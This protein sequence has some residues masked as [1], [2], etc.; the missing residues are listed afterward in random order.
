MPRE[1]MKTISR[2]RTIKILKDLKRPGVPL[3]LIFSFFLFLALSS[4]SS[5]SPEKGVFYTAG[6]WD[7]PPAYHGNP[8]APGGV[9]VAGAYV[10]EPLFVYNPRTGKYID[11]LGKSFEVSP[12]YKTLTV[13]LKDNVFWHDGYEFSS[14]DVKTTIY[15]G[16]LRNMEIWRNLE[17]VEC[18]DENTVIF[19][20]KKISPTNNIRAL[21][22][23][24]TSPYHIFGKWADMIP[25]IRK[26]RELAVDEESELSK[27]L[28]K[29]E[30]KVREVLYKYHPELPIG[31][32]PFKMGKVSASDMTLEKF[33]DHY[34][35][36][37][38]KIDKI[39][40]MRWA[41]NQVV[42]SYLIAGEVDAVSPACLYDVAQQIFKRNPK[43][44]LITPS[45][46]SEYGLIF[47]CTRKP[48][49]DLNFR[50]A[51]AHVLDRDMIRKVAYYYGTT[52]DDYSVG[53]PKSMRDRWI[54]PDF[55]SKL[56][57]YDHN[58]E[59]AEKILVEA[60]Y[61]RDPENNRWID[62]EG[63]PISLEISAPAGLTDLI[64]LAD[65][66]AAQLGKF[67]I[68][69]RIRT[70]PFE[71]FSSS[72]R[73]NNFDLAAENGAQMS[74]YG[75][76]SISYNRFFYKGGQIETAAGLPAVVTV[77]GEKINTQKLAVE[78]GQVVDPKREKEIVEKLALV[79]NEKLP[80]ISCYEK[81]IMI[82]T[83]N[84]KRVTG[85]PPGDDPIWACAPGGVEVLYCTLIVKGMIKPA[86]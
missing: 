81:R 66:A 17:D 43:I 36:Q 64:L 70:I 45:D 12:D 6:V 69:T 42:W 16:Y 34:E 40:I 33:N 67:G 9:G 79:L 24:I 30:R 37:N 54:D 26:H 80:F 46:M 82:F 58:L 21:T 72:L 47:N 3:L 11:R 10:H 74:K 48:T 49:S 29:K 41:S 23:R 53:L 27:S 1:N 22:E 52:I 51:V 19:K 56:T 73:D 39:R 35:A 75:H 86:P 8:W 20:W 84:G 4:C 7:I 62:P 15:I 2:D 5:R 85:W 44:K 38:V 61:S 60:G 76:P 55:Y 65:A 28:D 59:K 13:H 71:L 83:Q 77:D 50:R 63:R 14:K 31:T 25:E 68:P 18:P 78:L 32:G 57:L